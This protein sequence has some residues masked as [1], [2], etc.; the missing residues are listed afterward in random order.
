[1]SPRAWIE[2][3]VGV[4]VLAVVVGLGWSAY[5]SLRAHGEAVALAERATGETLEARRRAEVLSDSARMERE[6][7]VEAM[8]EAQRERARA[9]RM[10]DSLE[11]VGAVLTAVVVETGAS[12][13]EAVEAA[14]A[15]ATA[16][17]RAVLDTVA[18]RLVRHLEA[19]ARQAENFRAQMAEMARAREASDSLGVWWR[20]RALVTETAL[21]ARELECQRCAISEERWRAAAQPSFFRGLLNDAGT[22]VG[23]VVVTTLTVVVILL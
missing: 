2:L 17:R 21:E 14:Q 3:V 10:A 19:D 8:A 1:M 11:A 15:S 7:T 9:D 22:I 4:V 23:T 20:E 5:S 16:T 12:L 18:I 13:T 6:R